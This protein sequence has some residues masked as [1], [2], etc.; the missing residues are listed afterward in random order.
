MLGHQFAYSA[1]PV[2]KVKE[3]KLYSF[4]KRDSCVPPFHV[5]CSPLIFIFMSQKAICSQIKVMDE[6][7]HKPKMGGLMDPPLTGISRVLCFILVCLRYVPRHSLPSYLTHT[8]PGFIIK[9]KKFVECICVN[10][11]KA[12]AD[13]VNISRLRL[14][15][16]HP[17]VSNFCH[18]ASHGKPQTHTTSVPWQ[19][20]AFFHPLGQGHV[21]LVSDCLITTL[22]L[23]HPLGV[24]LDTRFRVI[25]TLESSTTPI[26]FACP[27]H[28]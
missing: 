11:G 24:R 3:V 27:H 23:L 2:R 5:Q 16:S 15:V 17:G 10:C 19:S 6:V 22:T 18:S 1:A 9:V 14:L 28:C 13:I 8:A 25:A 21:A 20:R 4:S 12:K 26:S 7:T